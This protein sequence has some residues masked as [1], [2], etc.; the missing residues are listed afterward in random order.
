MDMLARK[1]K[2]KSLPASQSRSNNTS[3][4]QL[5]FNSKIAYL[6]SFSTKFTISRSENVHNMFQENSPPKSTDAKAVCFNCYAIGHR[7]QDCTKPRRAQST[8]A[9][10]GYRA[11]KTVELTTSGPNG[12]LPK[13]QDSGDFLVG[14]VKKA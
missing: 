11:S 1:Y 4:L 10:K 2:N 14:A 12:K 5:V 13:K 8:T 7:E 6:S 3:P 9:K